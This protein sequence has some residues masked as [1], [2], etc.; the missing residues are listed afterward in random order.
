LVASWKIRRELG[1]LGQQIKG[2]LD[3]FTD[4]ISQRRLDR[5]VA[6]GLLQLDG[7]LPV[8]DKIAVFLIYQP[9]GL[10]ASTFE[11]CHMLSQAGYAPLVVS[12]C[13]LTAQ[14]RSRLEAVVWRAVERPNF[15]YD[16]G[17]Y[18]DGLTCLRQWGIAPAELLILNDSV[19]LPVSPQTDLL[20][21][22]DARRR[23]KHRRSL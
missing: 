6:A 18:R 20:E 11:T 22:S 17:G 12:N 13:P 15:G 5:A 19:W 2:I 14:D 4:P 1:R 7:T 23:S 9:T 10:A 21:R 3:R 8:S 16:F